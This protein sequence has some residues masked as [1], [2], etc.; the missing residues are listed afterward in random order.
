LND[1]QIF[2]ADVHA[3]SKIVRARH[4]GWVTV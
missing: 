1:D 4:N 3:D 2:F